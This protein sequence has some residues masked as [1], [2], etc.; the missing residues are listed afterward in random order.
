MSYP[1]EYWMRRC[2]DLAQRGAGHVSPNPLVGSVVVHQDGTLLGEGF[3][4]QFGEAHAEVNAVKNV[5]QNHNLQVLKESTLYVNLEPC[6]H[7]GKT[8]PCVDL[9]LTH[10]IPRVVVGMTDPFPKV[11]GS[12]IQR[13]RSHGIEVV[14]NVLEHDC[15]RLNEAF[16]HHLSTK[17]P[18]ITLKIAQTLDGSIATSN[19]DSRWV[20]GKASRSL[21]HEWRATM[22]AVLIGANT[23]LLDDPSLTVRHFEGR[24]PLRIVLDRT[25]SLP[26][27]LKLF[28]DDQ[29]IHTI[30]VVGEGYDPVYKALIHKNGGKL[31]YNPIKN[32]HLD[33]ET[34][35]LTLGE[36]SPQPIQSILVE[37]GSQL[38]TALM[39]QDL[40]DRLFLFIAPKLI[41]QGKPSF[42]D[43]EVQ[44][45]AQALS[46]AESAWQQVG[47][48][49]LFKGYCRAV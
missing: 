37:G 6:N 41:G 12:G 44:K 36:W 29:V 16:I 38:S 33:L 2:L 5:I 15:K 4:A 31:V 40:V 32:Q 49:M 7:F 48:D 10:G 39:K 20:T 42:L 13:L 9:I 47:D 26:D 8:P 18:L 35:F 34:L 28:N 19:G 17:N 21:V 1:H 22:D 3:H 11:A 27:T 23:A 30:V 45:M 46:F 14:E 43:L 25:G 24:N